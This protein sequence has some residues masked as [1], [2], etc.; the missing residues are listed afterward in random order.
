MEAETGEFS[1]SALARSKSPTDTEYYYSSMSEEEESY[2]L[3]CLEKPGSCMHADEE[4]FSL[5]I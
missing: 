1:V 4:V 2:C 3:K 5:H